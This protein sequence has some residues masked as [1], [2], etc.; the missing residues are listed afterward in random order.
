ME[1]PPRINLARAN[2]VAIATAKRIVTAVPEV[3]KALVILVPG[4]RKIYR[5]K[6]IT[7][8]RKKE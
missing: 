6:V 1:A 5:T 3:I 4:E 8:R 2:R 7:L